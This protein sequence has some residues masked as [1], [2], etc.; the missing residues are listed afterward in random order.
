MA[1]QIAAH[2]IHKRDMFD[3]FLKGLSRIDIRVAWIGWLLRIVVWSIRS[4]MET[5]FGFVIMA[6]RALSR[7]MEFQADL[8]SVSLTGSDALIHA[9]HK[10][11]AADDSWSR[12]LDFA[13]TELNQGRAVQNLFTVQQSIID[14]LRNIFDDQDYGNAPDLPNKDASSHRV[15]KQKLA[16]PPK[17]WATHPENTAREENAKRL[18][19]KAD[20]DA[21]SGWALFNNEISLQEQMSAD[22]INNSSADIE[23]TLSN[24][25]KER[26]SELYQKITLDPKYRG[27]YL[28]RSAVRNYAQSEDMYENIENLSAKDFINLYPKT[29]SEDLEQLRNLNEDKFYLQSVQNGSMKP[30]GGVVRF[31]GKELQKADIPQAIEKVREEIGVVQERINKSDQFCRSIHRKCAQN[32]GKG[33]EA[34]IMAKAKV[35]HYAQHTQDDLQ[36]VKGFLLNVWNVIWADGNVSKSELKRLIKACNEVHK[37]LAAVYEHAPHIKL[38]DNILKALNIKDWQE[39]LGSFDLPPANHDNINDWMQVIEGWVNSTTSALYQLQQAA[40]EQLLLTEDKLAKAFLQ[41][42]AT[43][44]APAPSSLPDKYKTLMFGEE[45]ELQTK[46][47][48]WDSFQT[49]HGLGPAIARTA[50][51]LSIVGAVLGG[52]LYLNGIIG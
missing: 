20:I 2:I 1:Q 52:G 12:T 4:L 8:V 32:L 45:R 3:S 49:A 28:G 24:D 51:S 21:R 29:L 16:H 41:N 27:A 26:L 50:V 38:D 44:D 39:G 47:N 6:Q 36:D 5:V 11:E 9:L 25:N 10:L 37:S 40:L 35:V 34:Y 13:S 30:Y 19:V 42:S 31:R 18:Y 46:L 22:L 33:W 7:E 15:F 14:H 43:E 17:M 23:K 48:W